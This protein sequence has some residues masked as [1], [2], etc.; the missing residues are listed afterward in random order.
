VTAITTK[1]VRYLGSKN[2]LIPLIVEV[3]EGLETSEKT[4][5]DV[6]TGTTR[7]AQ[8]FKGLG[9]K[10]TTS[11]MSW[12]SEAYSHAMVCNDGNNQ[13]LQQ[14]IDD[15]NALEGVPGWLTENY[16]DVVIQVN[17]KKPIYE[18]VEGRK[19]KKKVGTKEVV[20]DVRIQVWKPHNGAKADAIREKIEAYRGMPYG[21]KMSLIASLIF[22]LDKVDNTVGLQQAYLK[23]WK[24]KR[25]D[26]NLHLKLLPSPKGPAG[27]HITG[28]ALKIVYPRAEI[29]YLDPPYTP[30]DYSTYYHIWDSI[31]RWDKPE[32]T[33]KTNRRI[34]R[35]KSNKEKRDKNMISPWY[36]K[37]AAFEATKQ[38]VDRLPV[39]YVVFSYSDEGLI[40][41]QQMKEMGSEYK[42]FHIYA[43][44]HQRHVMSRIGAGG[45]KAEKA[46]IKKNVEYVIVIEKE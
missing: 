27:S 22:A 46:K 32:L 26:E 12:A 19:T 34:D 44:E 7:V 41:L 24:S 30:A 40:T 21:D 4:L 35:S 6:F 15:L 39:R 25:V 18:E 33:L 3:I 29:A 10:V 45:D 31:T 16:C 13:H 28:D 37:K 2:K 11:D 36:S 38:L 1:G 9:Y 20:E 5:I 14:H 42:S 8:A 17:S 43:K 23:D